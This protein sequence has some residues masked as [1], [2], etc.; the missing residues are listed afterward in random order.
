MNEVQRKGPASYQ[1]DVNGTFLKQ[2]RSE[3]KKL[4]QA[5]PTYKKQNGT[6]IKKKI[7]P[8]K[9]AQNISLKNMYFTLKII[10]CAKNTG[11]MRC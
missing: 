4:Q 1:D 2:S 6:A 9:N 3:S 10:Q 5:F 8:T 11:K 7:Q